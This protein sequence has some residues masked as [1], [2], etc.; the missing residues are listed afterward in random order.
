M[1][2]ELEQRL[3]SFDRNERNKALS[4]LCD[5]AKAGEVVFYE[6]GLAVNLH[7][8]TFFSYNCYG[9]SPSKIAYLARKAG[10]AVAGIVDFDVLDGLDEF[11]EAGGM[12]GLKTCAGLETRVF[13]P[14]FADKVINSPGE[15]GIAYHIG[16]G[17]PSARLHGAQAKFSA[18]L[19]KTSRQRNIGLMKRVNDYLNPV[20]L[21]YEKD[22]LC[23]TPAGNATERHLCIAYARKAKA[24]FGQG[25][26]LA[27]FWSEKLG[28][29]VS[30]FKG[31]EDVVLLNTIR[32]KT[33][34]LGG[35]GYVQP[36]RGAF[37][38]LEKMNEFILA[39]GGIPAVAW[40]DGTSEGEKDIER[41]LEVA[42][43]RGA[44]AI[45][46]VPDPGYT[47]CVPYRRQAAPGLSGKKLENLRGVL[48]VA[49]KLHL[50]VVAGTEMNS[51]GQSFVD[52]FD[53]QELSPFL[54]VFLEGAYIVYAH[55]VLQR[56]AGLGYTSGWSRDN[57]EDAGEKNEF[58]REVGSLL[59]AQNE[60]VLSDLDENVRPRQIIKRF[61]N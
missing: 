60:E 54:P 49:E 25:S 8:H 28:V 16:L 47:A 15:P 20:Q 11:L 39:A 40:L 14:E 17:F 26:E 19:R 55:S 1:V 51:P 13:V 31:P 23:L 59:E 36:D 41:L 33:M 12:L 18:G 38:E 29:E 34:K 3:D 7:C 48:E 43:A 37:P 61:V 5:R 2:E 24:L 46:V 56:A 50:P 21:D 42:M 35:V 6:P 4:V 9:Y 27:G 58:F 52:D 22:V 30:G 53:S 32:A 45:S 44:A 10:L 57:F